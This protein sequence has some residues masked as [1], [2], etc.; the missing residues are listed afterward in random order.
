MTS[1]VPA[2]VLV[3]VAVSWF[4]DTNLVGRNVPPNATTAPLTNFWPV[5][6]RVKLPTGMLVG[7][8]AVTTGVGLVK[9]TMPADVAVVS[10]WA[11]AV[12][13]MLAGFGI[14]R[15]AV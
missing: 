6:T 9:V 1:T 5:T 8:T 10:T 3:P 11:V 13:C 4:A 14:A 7:S 2:C 12:I 15:G